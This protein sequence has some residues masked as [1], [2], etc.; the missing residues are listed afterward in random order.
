MKTMPIHPC[1]TPTQ[2]AGTTSAMATRVVPATLHATP[3]EATIRI[4][5]AQGAEVV[6]DDYAEGSPLRDLFAD[7]PPSILQHPTPRQRAPRKPK[8]IDYSDLRRS[9]RQRN[10]RFRNLPMEQRAQR[11]LS[12]RLGYMQEGPDAVEHALQEYLGL[13]QGALP[14]EIV[15]ALVVLFKLD[16]EITLQRDEALI[17]IAGE[18]A[19]DILEQGA[20][21]ASA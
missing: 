2:P 15:V 21:G 7:P 9:E 3:H 6:D 17:R 19:P 20:D 13:Y 14:Q 4:G 18:D 12:K 10:S 1:P 5:G 8:V 11:V 16:D